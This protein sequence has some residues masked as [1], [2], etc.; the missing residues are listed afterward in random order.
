L[1]KNEGDDTYK[2]YVEALKKVGLDITIPEQVD[3][4][5]TYDVFWLAEPEETHI[6]EGKD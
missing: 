3:E 4:E 6:Q 1:Q 5:D 2:T